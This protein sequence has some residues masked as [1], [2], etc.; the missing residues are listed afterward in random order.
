MNLSGGLNLV[1]VF[2][3]RGLLVAVAALAIVTPKTGAPASTPEAW[4]QREGGTLV[5]GSSKDMNTKHPFTRV[6]SVDEY[7]K[8]LIWE[9]VIMYDLAGNLHGI[10]AE[11]WKPNSDASEWTFNLRRGVKFH[12]GT[13]NDFR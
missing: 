6:T 3:R 4:K 9:P 5:V 10:L 11:R 13:R 7:I 1:S 12:N 2:A 8:M